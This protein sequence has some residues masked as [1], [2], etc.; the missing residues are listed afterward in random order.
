[1]ASSSSMKKAGTDTRDPA[2]APS[3]AVSIPLPELDCISCAQR[4]RRALEQIPGLH[5]SLHFPE[6]RM[7]LGP[8]GDPAAIAAALSAL[9]ENG[10][11]PRA[12][13]VLLPLF[14]LP[15]GSP[16]AGEIGRALK[17]VPGVLRAVVNPVSQLVDV[18]YVPGETDINEIRQRIRATGHRTEG[19]LTVS[20]NEDRIE[21]LHR[22]SRVEAYAALAGAVLVTVLSLPLVESQA[23]TI[24][25]TILNPIQQFMRQAAPQLFSIESVGLEVFLLLVTFGFLIWLGRGWMESG[26]FTLLGRNP[27]SNA[28]AASAV[29]VLAAGLT[30][31]TIRVAWREEASYAFPGYATLFWMI[32]FYSLTRL[33]EA[34]ERR[35]LRSLDPGTLSGIH[36]TGIQR[37]AES[38]ISLVVRIALC[39]ATAAFVLWFD[40][41]PEAPLLYA[42][43]AFAS[44]MIAT[45]PG[46]F[47]LGLP[48]AVSAGIREAGRRGIIIRNARALETLG[49]LRQVAIMK[50]RLLTDGHPVTTDFVL[51]HGT[52]QR[53]LLS[54]T[55]A[56][57]TLAHSPLA[58]PLLERAR[59]LTNTSVVTGFEEFPGEGFAGTVN[60]RPVVA[61][62][63]SFIRSKGFETGS[64]SDEVDRYASEGKNSLVV[65][66]DGKLSG[67]IA[68]QDMP[69]EGAREAVARLKGQG[70]TLHLF[71]SDES[72]VLES[73][74]ARCGIEKVTGDVAP[75][76]MRGAIAESG[77]RE[78]L[79]ACV[80]TAD[81]EALLTASTLA[82]AIDTPGETRL[83]DADVLITQGGLESLSEAIAVSRAATDRASRNIRWGFIYHALA[84]LLATQ[85]L[86]PPTGILISPAI[87]ALMMLLAVLLALWSARRFER[88]AASL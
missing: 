3:P 86:Y 78:Q 83:R 56:L 49:R 42:V 74:A 61:G 21:R 48:A 12:A 31:S 8:G 87:F 20:Q 16:A 55:S 37:A 52:D 45:A 62:K 32:A 71:G 82:I 35:R 66:V 58:A 14:D 68:L 84:I 43:I 29:F 5:F 33:I 46:M 65:V 9:S 38:S 73:I 70:V 39:V 34:G 64:I 59:A 2:T 30:V 28:A 1:M 72:A 40:F 63:P 26:S 11:D 27:D 76:E 19:P 54:L 7:E 4:L 6:R 88:E 41:A 57:A 51:L 24:A 25:R 15:S 60:G 67:V 23:P 10:F 22:R 69:V 18:W 36:E 81:H 13:H 79:S 53:T 17:T 44:V 75:R 80:A 47:G 85:I 50:E 77:E